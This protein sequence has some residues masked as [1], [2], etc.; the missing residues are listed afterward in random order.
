MLVVQVTE[1]GEIMV[2]QYRNHEFTEPYPTLI[3]AL[4]ALFPKCWCHAYEEEE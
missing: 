3:E 2:A 4:Y 1:E